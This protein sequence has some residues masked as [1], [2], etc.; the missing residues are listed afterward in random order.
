MTKLHTLADLGQSIWYDYI[1]R[2]FIV[3]GELQS[4]V[5]QGVRGVTSNPS[6]FEK[7]I[8]GSADYDA[9]L[10]TLV[11]AGK[12]V[13]E[14][15]EALALA[16]IQATADILRPVFDGSNSA[17]GF[18]SLE[19][20]PTLAHDTV[21]TIAEARRLHAALDRPNVMIK[22]PATAEGIPAITALI[23]DGISVNVTLIF[24][25][26]QY[27]PVAQAYLAGLE[28]LAARGGD[29]SR[30]ASVASFF[31]SR[32]DTAVD[33]GLEKIGERDLQ[34]KIAVANAVA[35]YARFQTIFSGP[36]WARLA[37]Q[38]A[39]VQRPLW[40][41]TGT[42]NPLYPDTL[43]VDALIGPDTVNTVPPATLNAF[44]D[45]GAVASTL[46]QDVAGA[47]R[48]LARLAGLGID[49][50]AITARLQADGVAAFAQSFETLLASVAAKREKLL[51]E[52]QTL[53]AS[54]E[55][56]HR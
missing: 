15:Y 28:A 7:A 1:R 35:A 16:D 29:L 54:L 49:L 39:Q 12:S 52:G 22:V 51:A 25:T 10:R 44:L 8:A 30:V 31:V 33:A 40:A 48:Q 14:I 55:P 56:T 47:H 36:R 3:S 2:A 19:V 37:A 9:A 23:G 5:D 46:A 42:K 32:V 38:G 43:Y 13:A 41:S 34:G 27:E 17:D 50:D 21:G 26:A 20:S 6:I 4:L 11:D 45:H 24:S 18:V 53:S